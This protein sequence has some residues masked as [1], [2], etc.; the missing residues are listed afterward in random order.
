VSNNWIVVPT[1]GPNG[2]EYE[3]NTTTLTAEMI[4]NDAS[5]STTHIANGGT[6]LE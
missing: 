5:G 3:Y 6:L 4:F 1:H 2:I